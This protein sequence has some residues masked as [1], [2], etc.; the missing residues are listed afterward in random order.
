MRRSEAGCASA[1]SRPTRAP[2][3]RSGGSSGPPASGRRPSGRRRARKRRAPRREARDRRLVRARAAGHRRPPPPSRSAAR[4]SGSRS[5]PR[6]SSRRFPKPCARR[7]R[8]G[9]RRARA[10]GAGSRR[11][12][13]GS[14]RRRPTARASRRARDRVPR[15]PG[16]R[17]RAPRARTAR[18]PPA[19][20]C[21]WMK[22]PSETVTIGSRP[23]APVAA[24]REHDLVAARCRLAASQAAVGVLPL[25][26][27]PRLPTEITRH[28]EARRRQDARAVERAVEPR[29]G[30]DAAR[31]ER[32]RQQRAACAG[33]C[34]RDS[35][36][37]ARISASRRGVRCEQPLRSARPRARRC[38]GAATA[39]ARPSSPRA[40]RFARIAQQRGQ[41]APR[42]RR[43][44]PRAA[45]R[46]WPRESPRPGGRS[47]VCGPNSTGR[48]AKT[49]SSRLCPPTG[50]SVPPTKATSARA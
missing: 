23:C 8:P 1:A 26:P 44:P 19:R 28:G 45:R 38:R 30:S 4:E 31:R 15:A 14:R 39:R 12:E 32:E 29:A 50:T 17:A 42:A 2:A 48:P 43:H 40:S 33:L 13:P 21:A 16:R 11:R 35:S 25:P 22:R 18:R 36:H 5:G 49:G 41:R 10:G 27:T 3:R 9:R 6:G 37:E 24:A 46:H 34:S 47:A 20:R 7:R